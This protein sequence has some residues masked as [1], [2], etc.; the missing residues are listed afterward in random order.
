MCFKWMFITLAIFLASLI[1][2][3]TYKCYSCDSRID[4]N[5]GYEFKN[6]NI[7]VV[8]CQPPK[9]CK[10]VLLPCYGGGREP[11]VRGCLGNELCNDLSVCLDC[12]E[13]YCNRANN[14]GSTLEC[15]K[16]NTD[17]LPECLN[18]T[19]KHRFE[20]VPC[21]TDSCVT[22]ALPSIAAQEIVNNDLRC[23]VCE[24]EGTDACGEIFDRGQI[25]SADCSTLNYKN[26]VRPPEDGGTSSDQ[27]VKIDGK[28]R[29]GPVLN[30]IF[31]R[32]DTEI[33]FKYVCVKVKLDYESTRSIVRTCQR[34]WNDVADVC[35]YINQELNPNVVLKSCHTCDTDN[36]NSSSLPQ[37]NY[38]ILF[39]V[40]FLT[41]NHN[42]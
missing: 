11:T 10:K 5:C 16:C 25:A 6:S 3:N 9:T 22:V 8:N 18:T 1:M 12:E 19:S 31:H 13:N 41:L 35:D 17:D 40:I 28:F 7:P 36:C 42:Y 14:F 2:A 37:I 26:R 33:S 20:I 23:F 24:L 32:E 29:G 39:V 4:K 34:V 21:F 30:K 27:L 15:Y 38:V